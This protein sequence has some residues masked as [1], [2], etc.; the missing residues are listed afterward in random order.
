MPLPKQNRDEESYTPIRSV[1]L[2]CNYFNE[3]QSRD[4]RGF[5]IALGD[6]GVSTWA[7]RHLTEFIQ[8]VTLRA[9]EVLL[10]APWDA[11]VDVWNLC[12]VVL[13]V[14]RNVRMFSG[15]IAP[16]GRYD[17]RQHLAEIE[18]FFGPFP[19]ELLQRGNQRLVK[20]FFDEEGRVK[21]A[22]PVTRP[23]LASE[24]YTPGMDE[25]LQ[26]HFVA[27]ME[28][29]MKI[30]PRERPTPEEMLELPWLDARAT[31]DTSGGQGK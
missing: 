12:A 26:R 8:P 2:R 5:D 10:E 7:D 24:F 20:E 11:K 19:Q 30:N 17:V 22:Q 14:Y 4:I 18:D 31:G 28:G 6:W 3:A 29:A 16:D 27:F 9:P 13:E 21:G 25:E 15:R 23:G 1:P